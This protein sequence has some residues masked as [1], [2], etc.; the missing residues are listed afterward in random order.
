[1]IKI[2][3]KSASSGYTL[4]P[5]LAPCRATTEVGDLADALCR[6][7]GTGAPSRAALESGAAGASGVGSAH[8]KT[9][10]EYSGEQQPDGTETDR[11]ASPSLSRPL[12]STPNCRYGHWLW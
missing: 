1:M 8:P 10:R 12:R 9:Q 11:E 7:H 2:A 5:P 4:N 6:R 3:L